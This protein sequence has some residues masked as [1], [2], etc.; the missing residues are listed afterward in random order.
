[1][2]GHSIG[3]GM[4]LAIAVALALVIGGGVWL[5]AAYRRRRDDL[6]PIG[7]DHRHA[8]PPSPR[9]PQSPEP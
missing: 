4:L 2:D 6:A 9:D 1:M 7:G 5:W 3:V 8:R